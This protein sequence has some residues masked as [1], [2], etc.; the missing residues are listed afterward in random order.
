MKFIVAATALCV[1]TVAITSAD[2]AKPARKG[3]KKAATSRILRKKLPTKGEAARVNNNNNKVEDKVLAEDEGYWERFLQDEVPSITPPPTPSPTNPPGT[4]DTKVTTTCEITMPDGS[5]VECK[6]VPTEGPEDCGPKPVAYC[7]TIT[8]VGNECGDINSIDRTRS[9]PGTT[10]S[11]LG[12]VAAEDRN[13]CPGD[14]VV[15]CEADTVD[16]CDKSCYETTIEVNADMPGSGFVCSAMDEYK[17]CV[18]PGCNVDVETECLA[19]LPDNGGQVPCTEIPSYPPDACPTVETE[20]CYT[21]SNIGQ[22]CGDITKFERTRS[23]PGTTEDLIGSIPEAER[24]LCPGETI[25]VC[26]ID[27]VDTCVKQCYE[28]TVVVEATMPDSFVCEADDEYQFCTGPGCNV[29]VETTCETEIDGEKV[30]CTEIPTE[31]PEE[32]GP[33]DI[34]YCYTVDNIGSSCGVMTTFERTW[35]ATPPGTPNTRDLLPLF[36]EQFPEGKEYCPE[37]PPITVCETVGI[38]T[39]D[40]VCYET[41]VVVDATMPD[42]FICEATGEYDFCVEPGCDVEVETECTIELPNNGGSIA[43]TEIPV[44]KPDECPELPATNC[45]TISNVG[46]SCGVISVLDRTRTPPGTTESLLGLIPEESRE[47][48]PDETLRVCEDFMVDTCIDECYETSVV[49]EA[50]MEGATFTC[51]ADDKDTFCTQAGTAP[52]TPGPTPPPT[53]GPTPPPS[54]GPTPPPTPGPT[55]PPTPG[56]TPPPTPGPTPPP[57][58][59]PTL[60]PTPPPTP[61]PVGECELTAVVQCTATLENGTQVECKEMKPT[62]DDCGTVSKEYC[63]VI[64]NIG[65]ECGDITTFQRIRTPPGGEDGTQELLSLLPTTTLCPDDPPIRV[66]EPAETIDS[67][68]DQCYLTEVMVEATMPGG[69]VCKTDDLY[70]LC[71]N[72]GCR[73]ETDISCTLADGSGTACEDFP[74]STVDEC[75]PTPV[76]YC[77]K[78]DNV[79]P[80]C[81]T[82]NKIDRTR[83]PPGTTQDI[84]E[85][86]IPNPED[87]LLCGGESI[88]VCEIATVDSCVEQCYETNIVV[89]ATMADGFL[90]EAVDEYEFCVP[91]PPTE[92]CNVEVDLEC[93]ID[94]TQTIDGSTS[95]DVIIPIATRCDKRASVM[96]WRFNGGDC[97]Q[98]FNIQEADKFTCTDFSGGAPTEGSAWL[99]VT[100]VKDESDVYFDGE[101]R[102]GDL[103]TMFASNTNKGKFD[104]DSF[105]YVYSDSTKENLIQLSSVHTSCSQNLFLKDKFGSVQLLIFENEFGLFTCFV[106]ATYSYTLSNE[107]A[108]NAGAIVEF[109][110]TTNGVSDDC[111][112]DLPAPGVIP[113]DTTIVVDKEI[114]I[115]MTV[116]QTYDTTVFVRAETPGG[117]T[118]SDTATLSFTSGN[119]NLPSFGKRA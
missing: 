63:Y 66:C 103:F 28:T 24:N 73:I 35:T 91:P 70:D 81:G 20:Y 96:T 45:Y 38:S 71:V 60:A 76:Q 19:T 97:E 9:P 50:D 27:E 4:C 74:G 39:C 65:N 75:G 58:P 98:S 7:Y 43:C 92:Q 10:E 67:C 34:E 101:V 90:C 79:G 77:Y 2:A 94:P 78:I 40:K 100:S 6:D 69:F 117:A 102:V 113:P 26:E 3:E 1:A 33:I 119:P 14:E 85:V 82:I 105:F 42:G 72:P 110:S 18:E 12:L 114:L 13:L 62:I 109:T 68:D 46:V 15:I 32:C 93:K 107:A 51:A 17:F 61:S 36:Y 80:T 118:C 111:L 83:T 41:S 23:P 108:A 95:C 86:L 99:T 48:C 22:S 37:D 57:T 87:R 89:D 55:P 5:T 47:L 59:G 106:G 30:L 8:N 52:P 21:I 16:T 54:P 104:A 44:Y 49:V 88:T 115:D 53:P 11:L 64:D 116:R 31:S 56:P 29:H 25:R 84:L 112:D